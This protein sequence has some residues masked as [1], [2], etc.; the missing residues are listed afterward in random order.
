MSPI[1]LDGTG[2]NLESGLY[3]A[4][5]NALLWSYTAQSYFV[6]QP[7]SALRYLTT[8]GIDVENQ[9]EAIAFLNRYPDITNHLYDLP[10]VLRTFT[11]SSIFSLELMTEDGFGEGEEMSLLI[12]TN[13][14]VS[15]ARERL[16][17]LEEE[18][19]F[20][21]EESGMHAFS[22]ALEYTDNV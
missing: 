14:E 10:G 8:S 2:F 3:I 4:N 21:I 17:I 15:H 9:G 1:I 20:R 13:L 18:W 12:R 5:A 19:L 16:R 22:F 11:D 7:M 6:D